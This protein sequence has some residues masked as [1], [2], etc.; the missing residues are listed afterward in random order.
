MMELLSNFV[1]ENY[2]HAGRVFIEN[3]PG[4]KELQTVLI[5]LKIVEQCD[6][7]DKQAMAMA[8]ILLA[9]LLAAQLYLRMSLCRLMILK[10]TY[11]QNLI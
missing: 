7:T 1:R 4:K 5:Y 8:A 10:T 6:T 3:L 11:R 2:G 9:D